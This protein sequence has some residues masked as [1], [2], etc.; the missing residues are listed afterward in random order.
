M[1][2]DGLDCDACPNGSCRA[3][4]VVDGKIDK[5]LSAFGEA[6]EADIIS[7]VGLKSNDGLTDALSSS[8]LMIILND[9]RAGLSHIQ[10]SLNIRMSWGKH[11]PW[12][13]CAVPH[14][15]PARGVH[16]AKKGVEAY[17][18]KPEIQHHRLS[19]FF[20]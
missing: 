1:R 7:T 19:V 16:W 8:D 14:P 13:L 9:Y 4:E 5:V 18:Q 3:W 12:L 6:M 2:K 11:L 10:L 17:A 15:S 20:C